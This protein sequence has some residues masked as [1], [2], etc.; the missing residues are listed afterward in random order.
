M[1]KVGAGG[2]KHLPQGLE[3]EAYSCGSG[4]PANAAESWHAAK[5]PTCRKMKIVFILSENSLIMS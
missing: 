2:P 5:D 1:P 3:L 4:Y